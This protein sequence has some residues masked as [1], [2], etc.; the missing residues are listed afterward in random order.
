MLVNLSEILHDAA[1]NKYGIG[2]FN[3]I[4]T[5]MLQ[6]TL[7]AAEET[8]SPIIIGSSEELM[9]YVSLD[10][11]APSILENAKRASVPVAVHFDHGFTFEGCMEALRN[12]FTSIMFDGSS[13]PFEENIC[14]TRE[15]VR[16]A[17]SFGASVEG[18]IGHVGQAN[19]SEN[20][21]EDLYTTAEQAIKF[22]QKTNV[23]AL[24][25][26]IGTAHGK[27]IKTPKLD[28]ERLKEI[29][30]SVTTPLVLHGGSGVSEEDFKACVQQGISKINVFTDLCAAGEAAGRASCKEGL[31]YVLQRQK[32]Y[33]MM[34][35]SVIE[36][37]KVFGSVNRV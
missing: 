20:A 7:D 28:L 31:H 33:E 29:H 15:I 3:L 30:S 1:K 14:K 26:S 2:Y 12:G 34:K 35:E 17:H 11:L 18:E 23:D 4:D 13:L 10:L 21:K 25:V 8:R 6:A 36:K 22:S 19:L 32:R 16:V 5:D 24:A 37:L 27:Y 9:H